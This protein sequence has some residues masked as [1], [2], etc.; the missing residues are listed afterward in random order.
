MRRSRPFQGRPSS[1]RLAVLTFLTRAKG[2]VDLE[3][4]EGLRHANEMASIDS[5]SPSGTFQSAISNLLVE[6]R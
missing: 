5:I 4:G 2:I 3:D 6:F 1:Y